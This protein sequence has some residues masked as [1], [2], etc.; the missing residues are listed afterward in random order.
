MTHY[1][2]TFYEVGTDDDAAMCA[3]FVQRATNGNG[4]DAAASVLE[5]LPNWDYGPLIVMPNYLH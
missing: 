5:Q 3:Q 2:L 1:H 4:L